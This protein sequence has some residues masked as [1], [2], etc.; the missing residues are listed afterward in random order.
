[1]YFILKVLWL[2]SKIFAEDKM[3]EVRETYLQLWRAIELEILTGRYDVLVIDEFMAAYRYD[4][5]PKEEAIEFLERNQR[6][7]DCIDWT[8]SG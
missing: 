1:M 3:Q 4:L 5:I 2:F 6:T 7:G 8:K